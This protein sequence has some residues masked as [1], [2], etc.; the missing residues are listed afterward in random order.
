MS[1]G[2]QLPRLPWELTDAIIDHL[3]SDSRALGVCGMVCSEWLKRS[4]HYIFSTVQ[5]WP[6]RVR[7]FVHLANSKTSTIP[8]HV[9]RIELDDSRVRKQSTEN[10]QFCDTLSLLQLPCITS[11]VKSMSIRNVDWTAFSPTEQNHARERLA[12]FQHLNRLEFDN[13]V[14][15]DLREVVRILHS[16]PLIKY[17]KTDVNFMKYREHAVASAVTLRL[18]ASLKCVE[19]GPSDDAIPV[20]LSCISACA[21]NAGNAEPHVE[22]LSI[23]GIKVDH[24]PHVRHTIRK[25][26]SYLHRL[27]LGLDNLPLEAIEKEDLS[28]LKFSRLVHLRHLIIEGLQLS[29]KS[30]ILKSTLPRL[31][32]RLESPF[33]QLIELDF[34]FAT[35]KSRGDLATDLEQ[36]D[37]QQL[38]RVLME[39][40]FFGL[41]RV[42]MKIRCQK[43]SNE[44]ATPGLEDGLRRAM[45]RTRMAFKDL[46]GRGVLDLSFVQC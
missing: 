43:G 45:Q 37:W 34:V 8:F 29:P 2:T 13:V 40:H 11:G 41:R 44:N 32:S 4:R 31:L 46:D 16:F 1:R 7:D 27:T 30:G 38:Q 15:H 12:K 42:A 33:L 9:H 19:V 20:V 10:I 35:G 24:L 17:L 3:E 23:R 25:A 5:L 18:P 36:L 21:A 14:F 22:R 26:G 39:L 6:W 28:A